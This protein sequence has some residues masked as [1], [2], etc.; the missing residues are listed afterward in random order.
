MEV[1]EVMGYP[2]LSSILIWNLIGSDY[3][4]WGTPIG[5][6]NIIYIYIYIWDNPSI[7]IVDLPINRKF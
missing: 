6:F 5:G 2:K 7:G 1:S 4:S 3:Q